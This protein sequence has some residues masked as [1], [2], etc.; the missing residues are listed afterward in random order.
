MVYYHIREYLIL[1]L[2]VSYLQG[3]HERKFDNCSM[4]S[5]IFKS[6]SDATANAIAIAANTNI[7][8]A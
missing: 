4:L 1:A 6:L 7:D 3:K 8:L 2:C 5:W